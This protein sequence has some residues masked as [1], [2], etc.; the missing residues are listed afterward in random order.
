MGIFDISEAHYHISVYNNNDE[1]ECMVFPCFCRGTKAG[2]WIRQFESE[3][4]SLYLLHMVWCL[5]YVQCPE[6]C[7]TDIVVGE[8]GKTGAILL[9]N[10]IKLIK[11]KQNN[12][13]QE[14]SCLQFV[15]M[16]YN[17][18]WQECLVLTGMWASQ[19]WVLSKMAGYQSV[20]IQKM[21]DPDICML[22]WSKHTLPLSMVS[23]HGIITGPIELCNFWSL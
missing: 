15:A 14:K 17:C 16:P 8:Y 6:K 3:N 2:Y 10:P 12:L 11:G 19:M 5:W 18:E 20:L 4:L 21:C 23:Y 7:L 22:Y 1:L 9:F 13:F